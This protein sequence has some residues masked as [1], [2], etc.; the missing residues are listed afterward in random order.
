MK[1]STLQLLRRSGM[2][3]KA[4]VQTGGSTW[5]IQSGVSPMRSALEASL[6]SSSMSTSSLCK[7]QQLCYF[8]S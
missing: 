3:Q 2:L 7:S 5:M 4:H 8:C 1:G 6:S